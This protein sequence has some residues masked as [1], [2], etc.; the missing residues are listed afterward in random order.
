MM[1]KNRIRDVKPMYGL[2]LEGG[3]AKGAYHIGAYRA[4]MEEGIEIQ[5]IAGTSVGALNGAILVQGDFHKAY[6]LWYNISYSKV[7]NITD[8]EI[9]KLR[10]GKLAKEDLG[11]LIRRIGNIISDRGLDISPLKNLLLESVDEDKIRASGKDFG[12]VTVSLSD[13]KPLELYIENI[14]E[15]KLVDYLLASA[16]LPAFKSEKIEGKRYI[17]GAIYNNL[18]VNLLVDKG[19][20]DLIIIRTHGTGQVRKVNLN[21]LNAIFIAPQEDL[22]RTLDFDRDRARYNLKLGYY[23]G[24]RALKNLKGTS[25]YIKSI[26]E[27]GYFEDYLWNLGDEKINKLKKLF[28]IDETIPNRKALFE[29]INPKLFNL[30]DL[31]KERDYEEIFYTLIEELATIYGLER[32]HIY[33]YDKLVSLIKKEIKKGGEE[34]NNRFLDKVIDMVDIFS[35]F[36]REEL[37]KEV[38]KIL[39]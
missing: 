5:G 1:D 35:I 29:F 28:R 26:K 30:L 39:L 7:L 21:N 8:D 34:K 17:D 37:I 10:S 9:E 36:T 24:K 4:I 32:F 23:D 11:L 33:D 18:P 13:L 25:Y 2:V 31:D 12:I 38:G 14:P 16:Y 15:G 3:G 27:E 22:C 19:Y 20:E 6:D